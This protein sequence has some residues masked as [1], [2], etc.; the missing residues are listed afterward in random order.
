MVNALG[1]DEKFVEEIR[2]GQKRATVRYPSGR[3]P[4]EG[5][6]IDAVVSHDRGPFARIEI[7]NVEYITVEEILNTTFEYHYNYDSLDEFNERLSK[8]YDTPFELDEEF[9]LIEF[10]CLESV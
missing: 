4:S 9:I 10:E 8:Y 1:F 6:V 7:T 3:Q 5:T 2:D